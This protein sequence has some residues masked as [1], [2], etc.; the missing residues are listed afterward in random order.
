MRH[1]PDGVLRRLDDEPL[2]VPDRV[3]EH[4]RRLRALQRAASADRA[5]TPSA[6]PSCC[7]PRGSSPT[8][9]SRGPVPARAEPRSA[10]RSRRAATDARSRGAGRFSRGVAAG[11]AG[12]R[13]DRDRGRRHGGGGHADHDLRADPRGPGVPEPER[14]AERSRAFTGLGDGNR[15]SAASRRRA[16]R[17]TLRF[18]TIRWSSSAGRPGVLAR[19]GHRGGRLS[20][21]APRAPARGS[22]RRPA[23][24]RSAARERHRDLQLQRRE[25]RRELGD[26]RRR[27][28]R[29]RGVRRGERDRRAHARGGDDAAVRRRSPRARA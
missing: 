15:R 10:D 23:V 20:G 2:A 29:P 3:T 5:T 21:A 28:G 18:G 26:P 9:T 25:P 8:S 19:R 16:D 17:R 22:G 4:V 6:R 11:R 7:P 24:H 13:R 27:T 12:D 14:P 1:V